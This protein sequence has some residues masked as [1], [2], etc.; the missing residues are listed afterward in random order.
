MQI[1]SRRATALNS[2]VVN[3]KIG[4]RHP[5]YTAGTL[6]KHANRRLLANRR[7]LRVGDS[8]YSYEPIDGFYVAYGVLAIRYDPVFELLFSRDMLFTRK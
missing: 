6:L 1:Y 3:T 8:I 2:I 5:F 4:D 7:M